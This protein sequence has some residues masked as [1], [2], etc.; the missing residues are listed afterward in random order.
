MQM[1]FNA[2][3]YHEQ[4]ERLRK[5]TEEKENEFERLLQEELARAIECDVDSETT[6][7]CKLRCDQYVVGTWEQLKIW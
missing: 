3:F 2:K 1:E 6:E 7:N 5:D 4:I